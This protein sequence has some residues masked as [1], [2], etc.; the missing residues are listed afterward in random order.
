M[1]K[2]IINIASD[3]KEYIES[4]MLYN[5]GNNSLSDNMI[6]FKKYLV[7]LN[8]IKKCLA[9]LENNTVNNDGKNKLS[10]SVMFLEGLK[11]IS[12]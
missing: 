11:L 9:E 1:I 5:F 2:R 12:V 4:Y 6:M 10:E 7:I 8:G 3:L